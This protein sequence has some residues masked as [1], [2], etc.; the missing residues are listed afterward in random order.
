MNLAR[1][2]DGWRVR[3]TPQTSGLMG[4]WGL[5]EMTYRSGETGC[6]QQSV[7]G[8]GCQVG[9]LLG[10]RAAEPEGQLLVTDGH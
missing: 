4:R 9:A 10:E 1:S 5:K 2:V 6:R 7:S 8:F 3:S